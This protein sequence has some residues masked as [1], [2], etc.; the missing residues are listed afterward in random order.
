MV[1]CYS[2]RTSKG[3]FNKPTKA[4]M[5]LI[6]LTPHTLNL[7][8]SNGEQVA[9]LEA[10]GATARVPVTNQL[11]GEVS[12]VPVYRQE[13]GE[14]TGLPDPVE[15]VGY[16][17]SL[18]VRLAVPHRTDVYSPGELV[19]NDQGQPVGCKGLSSN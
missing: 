1:V 8:N 18:V 17:V 14:V 4:I 5:K 9:V 10:S 12:G 7:F 2:N 15:G 16:V 19:R 3:C 13:T 11:A 6:N